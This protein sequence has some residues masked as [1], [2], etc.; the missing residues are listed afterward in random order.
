M[1]IKESSVELLNAKSKRKVIYCIGCGK[2]LSDILDLYSTES[3]INRISGLF[4]NNEDLWGIKKQIGSRKLKIENPKRLKDLKEGIVLITS[5]HY[6]EIYNSIDDY[7]GNRQV[8]IFR[9]PQ[10]YYRWTRMLLRDIGKLPL[11]RQILFCAGSEP[12]ENA[13]EIVRYLKGE[14]TG[15]KYNIVYLGE[16]IDEACDGV[17]YIKNSAVSQKGTCLEVFNYCMLYGRSRYLCYENQAL[18]KTS[19]NQCLIYLNHGTI[20]LKRVSDVLKQPNEIDIGVCPGE[21]CSDLYA[22]QYGIPKE[23]QI[24][25]MPARVNHMLHTEGMI[26]NVLNAKDKKVVLWLP[27]FRQLKG[28]N[29][30][31]STNTNPIELLEKFIYEIDS[32]LAKV[33]VVIAVKKHPRE[34]TELNIPNTIENIALLSDMELCKKNISLQDL[35]KDSDA[36]ITDYSGISFEY[37][38]LDRPIGYVI[39]DIKEYHRGFSVDNP[40]KYM[41]GEKIYS[42]EQLITFI[43]NVAAGRDVFAER[44]KIIVNELF[45]NNAY[46]NGAEAFI[47]CLDKREERKK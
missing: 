23:K 43:N 22:E 41:P 6:A 26:H 17:K 18:E 44:R 39:S 3:F 4:D 46:E 30:I 16:N 40:E 33:G 20:P 31:D 28:S 9:Y 36:L 15:K 19:D 34:K 42:K 37:M 29:R 35:L 1:K 7:L 47:Q 14:Y 13:D 10:Y 21:G 24:Y 12:H 32:Y 45:G 11:K 8:E 38:L 2:R 25:M 27:T 5:D